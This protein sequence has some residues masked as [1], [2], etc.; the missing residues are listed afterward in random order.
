[1]SKL[2]ER[3]YRESLGAHYP[4]PEDWEADGM[5]DGFDG[6]WEAVGQYEGAPSREEDYYAFEEEDFEDH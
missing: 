2:F 4:T 3:I 5:P 6:W 1:M